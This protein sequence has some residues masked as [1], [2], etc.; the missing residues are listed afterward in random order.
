MSGTRSLLHE[1]GIIEPLACTTAALNP[2]LLFFGKLV[3]EQVFRNMACE[4]REREKVLVQEPKFL[5][6]SRSS[7]ER[8][9]GSMGFL[10]CM[11][12]S[13]HPSKGVI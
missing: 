12:S 8:L 11:S 4:W 13:L 3:E 9:N 1:V 6:T 10:F 2:P 5:Q 7:T